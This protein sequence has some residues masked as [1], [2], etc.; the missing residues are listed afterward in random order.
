MER[1]AC[2]HDLKTILQ[3]HCKPADDACQ[4]QNAAL[5]GHDFYVYTDRDTDEVHVLYRRKNGGYG[6]L[7]PKAE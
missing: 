1:I 4:R 6:L 5:L 2:I 3:R 7:K